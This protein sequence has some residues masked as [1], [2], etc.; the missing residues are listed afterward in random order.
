MGIN[1]YSS[2]NHCNKEV[3]FFIQLQYLMVEFL[4]SSSLLRDGATRLFEEITKK[5]GIVSSIDPVIQS[6]LTLYQFYYHLLW[7]QKNSDHSLLATTVSELFKFRTLQTANNPL[8]TA[9]DEFIFDSQLSQMVYL[10][11]HLD[12]ETFRQVVTLI[13][14]VFWPAGVNNVSI[15]KANL[16]FVCS[17]NNLKYKLFKNIFSYF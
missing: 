3:I 4:F 16:L 5:Q 2:N 14:K 6:S 12:D 1:H 9:Y 17:I 7:Y 8:I 11:R 10:L 15:D 13:A